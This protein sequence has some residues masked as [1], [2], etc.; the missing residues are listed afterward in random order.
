VLERGHFPWPSPA[1]GVVRLTAAQ[2]ARLWGDRL[3][4]PA[5]DG[6]AVARGL[7]T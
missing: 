3:A 5:M 2:L 7:N 6:T 1:D 4:P